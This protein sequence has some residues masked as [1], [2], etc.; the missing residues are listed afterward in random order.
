MNPNQVNQPLEICGGTMKFN[1]GDH[2]YIKKYE[3]NI[4]VRCNIC[5]GSGRVKIKEKGFSCPKCGGNG[6]CYTNQAG[7][8][9]EEKIITGV[10]SDKRMNIKYQVKSVNLG[11]SRCYYENEVF[12]NPGDI[13]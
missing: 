10:I 7:Y 13:K 11:G 6:R 5:D 12:E 9:P 1:I 3:E 2:V 8:V 4:S